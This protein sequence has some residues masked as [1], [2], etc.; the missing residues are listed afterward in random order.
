MSTQRNA[1]DKF[2]LIL[3]GITMGAANKV[4]GVSG[5]L[6]AFVGGFYEEFIYSLQKINRKA[7]KLLIRGRLKSLS[8]Y[9]NAGFLSLLCLGMIISYFSV[10]KI[11]DY[12]LIGYELQV[13]SAFFG[14]IIGS[15]IYIAQRFRTLEQ[16]KYWVFD[17]RYYSR[18]SN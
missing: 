2:W 6:V 10:S 12:L 17:L 11:L 9:T 14:M 1:L 18:Y 4:P 7:F 5:G 16:K 8:Q 3:K 13:W 15:I